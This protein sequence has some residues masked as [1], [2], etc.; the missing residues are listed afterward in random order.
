MARSSERQRKLYEDG[1]NVIVHVTGRNGSKAQLSLNVIVSNEEKKQ[2]NQ[3]GRIVV[4]ED[5]KTICLNGTWVVIQAKDDTDTEIYVDDNQDGQADGKTP[6]YTGD[7]SEYTITGVE[8]NAIRR[9]IR[10]TMT[11]GNVKAIYGAKDSELSYEGGDAVSINIRGGKAAT[12]Y[13]LSNS[14][15]GWNHTHMR[16]QRTL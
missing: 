5:E 2:D 15:V 10:I 1:K 16:S 14:T 6:L 3:D 4:D 7:L 9:S 13:V 8:D 12:M 11:G